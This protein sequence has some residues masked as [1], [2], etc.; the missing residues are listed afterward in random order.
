MVVQVECMTD[1]YDAYKH[2]FFL[3]NLPILVRRFMNINHPLHVIKL[4]DHLLFIQIYIDFNFILFEL[5]S[6]SEKFCNLNAFITSLR[7]LKLLY[8]SINKDGGN[9]FLCDIMLIK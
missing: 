8:M 3:M 2:I 1:P 7:P 6:L 5:K 9:F 4:F